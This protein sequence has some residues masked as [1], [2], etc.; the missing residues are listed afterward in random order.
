MFWEY[1]WLLSTTAALDTGVPLLDA[2]LWVKT[3][4]QSDGQCDAAGGVRA[5][6]YSAYSQPGMAKV[7]AAGARAPAA[8]T[9][10]L[11]LVRRRWSK[12]PRLHAMPLCCGDLPDHCQLEYLGTNTETFT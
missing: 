7:R 9:C 8:R 12:R 5:W 3:P 6:D 1:L 4:G 2:D 11:N 10:F